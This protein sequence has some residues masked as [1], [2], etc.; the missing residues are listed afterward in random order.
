MDTDEML[1]RCERAHAD[2]QA[3]P[4]W[5]A[6]KRWRRCNR[7]LFMVHVLEETEIMKARHNMEV[8]R[9]EGM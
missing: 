9:A 3:V 5:R 7:W 4:R 6:F 2:W 1:D 8:R